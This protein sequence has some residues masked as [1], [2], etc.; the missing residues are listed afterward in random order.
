MNAPDT[1]PDEAREEDPLDQAFVEGDV[2]VDMA[3]DALSD[4]DTGDLPIPLRRALTV[5]LKQSYVCQLDQPSDYAAI[6]ADRRELA[7]ALANLG[8]SLKVSERY[9]CA[10]ATQ[11]SVTG[12]SPLLSLKIPLPLNRDATVLLVWLRVQQH[13]SETGG[14]ENWFA[15]REEMED[16][17]KSGPYFDDRD[18][19]RVAKATDS[20]IDKLCQLGYLKAVSGVRDRYRIMPILPAVFGLE[21]AHEL[22]AAFDAADPKEA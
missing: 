4:D 16:I 18:G 9:G 3:D 11:A 19:A 13:A 10:W 14:N 20:A 22:L 17:L 1:D 12:K 8:L 7:R 6:A 15:D 5:L 21:R 2:E